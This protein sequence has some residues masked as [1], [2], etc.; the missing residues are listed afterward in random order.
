MIVSAKYILQ[1]CVLLRIK[2]PARRPSGS[3]QPRHVCRVFRA[4]EPAHGLAEVGKLKRKAHH[5]GGLIIIKLNFGRYQ[6]FGTAPDQ[7]LDWGDERCQHLG[8]AFSEGRLPTT[9]L[10][11]VPW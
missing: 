5:A 11:S 6:R 2:L 9:E 4:R 7:Y 8:T 3:L 1:S 10:G